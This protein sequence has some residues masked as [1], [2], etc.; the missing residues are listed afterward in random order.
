MSS[1]T[2]NALVHTMRYEADGIVS[3][4]FR[5]ATPAVDFPAFEAGS[6]IDLHLPNGLVRSYSLCNPA[7]DRQR[8][9][10]GVLNDRKSRGGSRYVHQQLRVGMTL[11][12]SAP[13]NNFALEEDARR[14]VL[15]AG[16]IG[17]TPIWCMLQRLASLGRPVELVY[18]ARSRKEAA[19]VDAIEAL[20]RDKSIELSWHFDDEQ[21]APPDL[22]K[23]LAGRGDDSHYYC[24]GPTPML[25]AFERSCEQLGYANV[26]IERFAAV[27][28]EAPAA[29]QGCVVACAKS[30]REIEVP[31]GK[32][33]LDSLI[34]AGLDPDHSC[35]EGV[36]GACE[37]AVLEGEIDHH[38]GILTKAERAANKTMMICV[39]RCKGARLV[40]DI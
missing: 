22:A 21:G 17:V 11:P 34:D 18:C 20:A 33:I 9:V 31:A 16:G 10:V 14:S 3:V 7:S 25:D 6:H 19:F 35:K 39:S 1:P 40:L 29:T 32:S 24:C 26:H 38:D 27:H 23:L 5:P 36:C 28:V 15:V 2:L 12:I 13:R 30:Q 37:T 4:E 8:Y